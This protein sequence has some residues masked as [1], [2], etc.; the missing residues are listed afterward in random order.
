MT[1]KAEA[2]IHW[3][4]WLYAMLGL[5]E[6]CAILTWKSKQIQKVNMEKNI[7][8]SLDLICKANVEV[9]IIDKPIHRQNNIYISRSLKD[10][11]IDYY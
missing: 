1:E 2:L 10:R 3:K 11:S 4:G 8:F 5:L 9:C 6:S 7:R